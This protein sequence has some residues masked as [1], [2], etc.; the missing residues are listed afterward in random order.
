[1]THLINKCTERNNEHTSRQEICIVLSCYKRMLLFQDLVVQ[2]KVIIVSLN[3]I[4]VIRSTDTSGN[5]VV[6]NTRLKYYISTLLCLFTGET[7]K[8][9]FV[10]FRYLFPERTVV[11]LVLNGCSNLDITC[12]QMSCLLLLSV[13]SA[14]PSRNRSQSP[15]P[16]V[17]HS[18]FLPP[19]LLETYL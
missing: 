15:G 1:M 17:S 9:I 5:L 18:Q 19:L 2:H 10:N 11:I 13:K 4:K 14:G 8:Q 12:C 3:L 6:N 16:R 7:S